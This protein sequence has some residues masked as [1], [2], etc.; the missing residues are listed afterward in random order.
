MRFEHPES[1]LWLLLGI[2]LVVLHLRW[3]KRRRAEFSSLAPWRDLATAGT[4]RRGMR[5]VE[6]GLALALL[7]VA[8][9]LFVGAWSGPILGPPIAPSAR[10]SIV[11]DGSATMNARVAAG[12]TRFDAAC[13]AAASAI[14]RIGRA[15]DVVVWVAGERPWIG[16]DPTR[17]GAAAKAAV[18]ALRPTLQPRGLLGAGLPRLSNAQR[19]V[20]PLRSGESRFGR[21]PR[22]GLGGHRGRRPGSVD[23]Q[24]K[25]RVRTF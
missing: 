17:D 22:K 12:G 7:L 6:E 20:R 19:D 21:Q 16:V 13:R 14:D 5:R 3:R 2:P 18:A 25:R 11:I 15:D 9:V 24:A 4:A 10:L 8:L 1:G 23:R